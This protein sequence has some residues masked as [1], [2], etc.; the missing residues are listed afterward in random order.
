M[1]TT[2][3]GPLATIVVTAFVTVTVALAG[4]G[5]PDADPGGGS[6]GT[7]GGSAA[8]GRS[9]ADQPATLDPTRLCSLLEQSEI[10]AEFGEHGEVTEGEYHAQSGSCNW[11]MGRQILQLRAPF[12]VADPRERL[13]RQRDDLVKKGEAEVVD[14]NGVGD[15]AYAILWNGTTQL[16]VLTKGVVFYLY[17]ILSAKDELVTLAGHVVKRI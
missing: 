7:N 4:C 5:S 11:Q 14:V 17:T 3:N 15:Y 13:V 1:R 10:A 16:V 9:G 6:G 2:T 12:P 8:A